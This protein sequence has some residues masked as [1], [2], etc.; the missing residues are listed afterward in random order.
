MGAP[1]GGFLSAAEGYH[2]SAPSH[3][4]PG[5]RHADAP[6]GLPTESAAP[7]PAIPG[8]TTSRAI[9]ATPGRQAHTRQTSPHA[10]KSTARRPAAWT[11]HLRQQITEAEQ[12]RTRLAG[13]MR[14]GVRLRPASCGTPQLTAA[15]VPT[16][17]EASMIPTQRIAQVAAVPPPDLL[18]PDAAT[19]A[20][21]Q[22]RRVPAVDARRLRPIPRSGER[23]AQP[24]QHVFTSSQPQVTSPQ[25]WFLDWGEV[26]TLRRRLRK[27]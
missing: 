6:A 13:G 24:A 4:P 8:D 22:S 10:E 12:S 18:R 16:A 15:T 7:G 11:E 2:G 5:E 26:E 1:C 21:P 25:V 23:P 3:P 17:D 20:R 9:K 27:G 19:P 14:P